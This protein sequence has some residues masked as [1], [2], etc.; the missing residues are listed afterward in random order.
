MQAMPYVWTWGS[1]R[2]HRDRPAAARPRPRHRSRTTPAP[3]A[4]SPGPTRRRCSS[5]GRTPPRRCRSRSRGRRPGSRATSTTLGRTSPPGYVHMVAR[6]HRPALDELHEA[7][8]PQPEPGARP[9]SSGRPITAAWR[10]TACTTRSP[11]RLGPRDYTH[12][13][14]LA[15]AGLCHFMARRF[16]EAIDCERRAV[17]LRPTSASPGV[18]SPRPPGWPATSTWRGAP[19]PRHCASIHAVRAMGRESHGIV[20]EKDRARYIEGLRA[21]GLA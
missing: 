13:A 15:T 20:R 16:D 18:P 21:A 12:P 2:R 7:I 4:C 10:R 9:R 3:T 5:A 14:N 8:E 1:G 6:R 19:S 17:Q 11:A